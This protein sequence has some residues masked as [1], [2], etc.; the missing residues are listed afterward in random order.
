MAGENG[1]Q[2]S[3]TVNTKPA[4]KSRFFTHCLGR[5]AFSKANGRDMGAVIAAKHYHGAGGSRHATAAFRPTG[6]LPPPRSGRV[7]RAQ[8]FHPK[9]RLGTPDIGAYPF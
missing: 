4:K 2:R 3:L 5:I 8:C 6:S 9:A 7:W 1:C